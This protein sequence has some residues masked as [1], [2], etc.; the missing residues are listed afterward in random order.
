M[1]VRLF[2]PHGRSELNPV[3]VVET[4]EA[5]GHPAVRATHPATLQVTKEEWLTPRGDCVVAVGSSKG[6]VN[7]SEAFKKAA[8]NPRTRITAVFKVGGFIE[9]VKGYG[10]PGL[11]LSHPTDLVI[12]K[13]GYVC[14]RTLMVRADRS[15]S[16]FSRRTVT[17]LMD[18]ES[19]VFIKLTAYSP[20]GKPCS[21]RR[22][23]K[24]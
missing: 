22:Q 4:L 14:P 2:I 7:L 11:S 20:S 6:A 3:R 16:D 19:H 21:P 15:A 17:E 18:P 13:S 9:V 1:Q 12:R 8:Q 23:A 5:H 24:S 10:D